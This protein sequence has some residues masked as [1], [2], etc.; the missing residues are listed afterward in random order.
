MSLTRE[1]VETILPLTPLQEGILFHYT[2]S[3]DTDQYLVKLSL[4]IHQEVS[5]PVF[6]SAW[7]QVSRQHEMLRAV[8]RWKE[9][10]SPVQVIQKQCSPDITF[11]DTSAS[12]QDVQ[13]LCSKRF[14]LEEAT[15][16]ILLIRRGAGSYEMILQNHHIIYDGWSAGIILKDFISAYAAYA[17]GNTQATIPGTGFRDYL[18]AAGQQDKAAAGS[19]WRQYLHGFDGASKLPLQGKPAVQGNGCRKLI[20]NSADQTRIAAFA[21]QHQLTM[22]AL[23]YTAWGILL[24]RYCGSNDVLFGTVVSGRS[25]AVGGLEEAVGLFINT[26]P[27][28]V[29]GAADETISHLLDRVQ[30]NL[31]QRSRYETTALTDIKHYAH[32]PGAG[33][34]FDHIFVVENYPIDKV[35]TANKLLPLSLKDYTEQTSYV[36]NISAFPDADNMEVVFRYDASV[37][38]ESM[39]QRISGHFRNII[40]QLIISRPGQRLSELNM[41]DTAERDLLLNVFNPTALT[42]PSE[43]TVIDLFEEQ[44][45]RTPAHTAILWRGETVTYDELNMRSNRLSHYLQSEGVGN[46]SL[47]PVCMER[48]VDMIVAVLGILKTGAAYVPV[49]PAYPADRIL[50]ILEDIS[51]PLVLVDEH[52]N[53]PATDTRSVSLG[54][55]SAF[56]VADPRRTSGVDPL[57]SI[58]YTSG[59]S[60]APKGVQL[61][62]SAILNRLYWMWGLYPF[63]SGEQFALKTSLGFVDHIWELFGPLLQ[64]IPSV[65]FNNDDILDIDRFLQHLSEHRITRI[66]LVPSLLRYI[67]GRLEAGQLDLSVLQYW[68]SSGEELTADLVK[69]FYAHFSPSTHKLLNIYGSTEVAADVTCYDTSL[70]AARPDSEVVPIG[71]P[72]ANAAVYITDQAGDL[73]P[74]GVPGELLV[75]GLPVSP[76]YY[77]RSE[78]THERFI[79]DPFSD[80][81]EQHV[82]KTG[83][84]AF[85][86]ADGNLVYLGRKDNQVKL[87]GYRIEPG[88]V[89][90]VLE[91]APGIRQAVVIARGE[92]SNRYLAGYVTSDDSFDKTALQTFLRAKLPEYMV[93]SVIVRL[94]QI[95]LTPN[96]KTDRRSLA[97]LSTDHGDEHTYI[98]PEGETALRLADIWKHLL[99]KDRIGVTDNFFELG[100]HSLLATRMVSA[101]RKQLG[102][103]VAVRDI[104]N[105]PVIREL[106]RYLD[107]PG[108]AGITT[109]SDLPGII[110]GAR[111]ERIPLSFSQERLWFINQL[112]GSREYHIPGVFRLHG[113]VNVDALRYGLQQVINR[114]EVLRSV[115][116][117]EHD[118]TWQEILPED[119]WELVYHEVATSAISDQIRE[120]VAMPFHLGRDHMLRAHLIREPGGDHLLVIVLHHIASDG[121]SLPIL[122]R[123]F[124][125]Y[126]RSYEQ[127]SAAVLPALSIQYADYAIWQRRYLDGDGLATALSYWEERLSGS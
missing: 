100:G 75:K 79:T 88:E 101:I 94:P 113:Q 61:L 51:G 55:C 63:A 33:D 126:Y 25:L 125:A 32:L 22:A 7:E 47:V 108:S 121:W 9:L 80:Q 21:R 92:S 36:L 123:E 97:L 30:H 43:K 35:V 56:P 90:R 31:I 3:P 44:A 29:Y 41:L 106:A 98:A 91:Q 1:N 5:L 4:I 27:L 127:G 119:Q 10:G 8:F 34:I 93:P 24:Q 103:E 105:M 58:I 87:R 69:A 64:G 102:R 86:Q 53:V 42:I 66:V 23:L 15:W 50:L 14:D 89:E 13:K 118:Q 52:H 117:S 70:L 49:D 96:G 71:R 59:S 124:V 114:H 48:S 6:R 19:Y 20:F 74:V 18:K 81:Q 2:V 26:V 122:V 99:K 110:A 68:T 82:F 109:L 37:L 11:L 67:L 107:N 78:L 84:L 28:R 76:G 72:I 111:P 54:A 46:G 38:E 39:V 17:G 73:C 115:L 62:N 104:F 116:K 60:G 16:R 12:E 45:A 85:W 112:Q 40:Q 120:V 83:D 77:K 95:P 65:L 57:I